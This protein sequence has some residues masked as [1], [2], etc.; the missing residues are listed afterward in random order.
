MNR[1]T[2][3]IKIVT[4]MNDPR[5][6]N[7]KKKNTYCIWRS[8]WILLR[9][10]FSH[11]WRSQTYKPVYSYCV[12]VRYTTRWF[13]ADGTTR[14]KRDTDEDGAIL[15]EKWR[16]KCVEKYKIDKKKKKNGHV[17]T[18]SAKEIGTPYSWP[19]YGGGGGGYGPK[20]GR[21]RLAYV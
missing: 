18:R 19:T 15:R 13:A 16:G 9:F 3:F 1:T 8:F 5:K 11:R 14:E 4:K 2:R 21:D 10:F 17:L 6:R 12:P 7:R 20:V